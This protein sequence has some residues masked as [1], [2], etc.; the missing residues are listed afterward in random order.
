[1]GLI[2]RVGCER[3]DRAPQGVHRAF[4]V[5]IAEH[6]GREF[7]VFGR[8]HF[9]F[10]LAH[11][12]AEPVG[13]AGRVVGDTPGD[14]HDLLL[15]DDEAVGFVQDVFERFFQFGVDGG[16][17]FAPVFPVRVVQVGVNAHGAGPVEGEG[18]HDV[19]EFGGLHAFQ[20]FLHAA[21]VQLEHAEGVAPGQEFVYVGVGDGEVFQVDGF[22]PVD[23][24]VFQGVADDCEVAQAQEVHFEQ[25]DGFAG[26]VGPAGDECP[27]SGAFPHGDAVE[28]RHGGHDDGTGMHAGLPDHAFQPA[29]GVV[30]LPHIGVGFD[31]LPHFTGF[32]VAVVFGVHDAG[33]GDVFGHDG[34]RQH[35][36]DAV[37]DL[38]AGLAVKGPGGVFDCLFGFH[39]AEGNHLGDFVFAPAF[40]GV[41]DHFAA[42]PVVEVDVDVGGGGA[43][44]VEEPFEEEPV[45]DGVDVGDGEGVGDEG[46]GRRATAWAYSN[47]DGAGVLDKFGHDEEVGGVAFHVDDADFVFGA[48]DVVGGHFCPVE[49]VAQPVEDLVAE[50][51]GGGVAFGHVGDGHAVVGVGFPNAGVVLDAL[52][53]PEGV[54]AGVG[55][56][57]VPELAHLFGAFDEVA[58]AVE[59][60]PVGVA[61]GFAGLDAEHHFVGV[62]LGFQHIVAII[63]DQ[64]WQVE[65]P[66]DF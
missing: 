46:A 47:A 11:G 15:V 33:Q 39:R 22:V 41:A 8:Q 37:G 17:G 26:W 7:F 64:G 51:G 52:G 6:A 48:F 9:G 19:V 49:A 61:H 34:G 3:F 16:D 58:G 56:Q 38:V 36:G 66:A 40:R 10:F 54:V 18:G 50:P 32:G 43:F 4:A 62:G 13:F 25:A 65:F 28:E 45:V 24:N 53:D 30:D 21:G 5:P 35:F 1:M 63:G 55:D 42:A 12:F 60:E 23:F 44:R 59:F 57:V 14:F 20:E 2:E 29:G 27:V 31:E